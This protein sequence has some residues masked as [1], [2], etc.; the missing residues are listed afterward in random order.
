VELGRAFAGSTRFPP[1]PNDGRDGIDERKQ[2]GRVVGI[3]SREADGEGNAILVDDKVV[4]G[5][6][7][8][9]VR[10]VWS[11]LF[12]PLLARTLKLST[13]ARD[14]S[15]AASPPSEFKSRSCSF[16]QTPASCQSRSRRQQVV[17]LPQPSSCG[18]K[19]H[20]QPVR[21][22]KTMPPRAAQSGT[23]GRPPLGFGGS[24]GNRDSMASHK[25]PGT[26]DEAFM[27]YHHATPLRF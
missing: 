3:G 21:S 24:F 7:L 23:R 4:F 16:C 2:V 8:A 13:L 12:A 19:R 1:R 10:R 26:R 27:A 6:P 22:T 20:G 11:C 14:Q 9:A 25:S 5:A 18:N 15:M 17:P